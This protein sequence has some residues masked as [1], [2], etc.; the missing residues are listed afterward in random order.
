MTFPGR[1]SGL[2]VLFGTLCLAPTVEAFPGFMAGKTKPPV[3]HST[4]VVMMRK[5]PVTAVSVMPDYQGSLEPFAL[6]LALPADA[7]PEHVVTLK[8]EFIDRLDMLSAPRFHEFWEQD[9]CDPGP[10]EQ[11]WQRNLK[12]QGA[13]FLGGGSMTGMG[14]R[15]VEKELLLDTKAKL[16]EGEYKI[17]VL[18][19]GASPVEW[20]KSHGYAPPPRA[21]ELVSPYLGQGMRFA[22]AEVDTKRVELVGGDRAQLSPI[23][24]YTE[25]PYDTLP[26][27]LGLLNAPQKDKQ[28]IVVYVLDQERRFQTAN[29][30]NVHPPTNIEVDFEVKERVGEFYNALYDVI[31][32]KTPEAFLLEYA[33]SADGCGQP[34]ATDGL[35]ISELLSLGAD[36]FELSVS[37]EDKNPK[38]PELTKEE[39]E[40]NKE[41]WKELKP[42]ER[43][44]KEKMFMEDR[45]RVA[46]VKALVERHKYI[47]SRLHYRY[48]DKTLSRDP[49]FAAAPNAVEGGVA[50]PKGEKREVS[51]EVKGASANQLQTRYINFHNWKP[52]IKCPSPD[53]WRWGKTPPDVR[54]LRK[55]WIAEDL[56]RKSRTQIKPAKMLKVPIPALGLGLAPV[57][58]DAGADGGAEAGKSSGACGCRTPGRRADGGALAGFFVALAALGLF[59]QRRASSVGGAIPRTPRAAK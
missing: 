26:S 38:P 25:Q 19:P 49:K 33:W 24:F 14:D 15:K 47:V 2:C 56:T 35:V 1:L 42:K 48:D 3:V 27:R 39:K 58:V 45:E 43:K 12:V 23:R 29:Y 54:V 59:R 22:V 34:C 16:K 5:G 31:L 18:E 44:E 51:T 37:E 32:A 53:R 46:I 28:E 7:G 30:T 41:L 36:V 6:V 20:L 4:H 17:S 55:T 8:R 40:A 9:P 21:D 13:G 11:E 50:L 57:V 10:V 52:V